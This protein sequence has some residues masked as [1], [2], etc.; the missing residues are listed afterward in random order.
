M[1]EK[2][3]KTA[4]LN[5]RISPTLKEATEKAAKE[6]SRS[7]TQTIEFL[8]KQYLKDKGYLNDDNQKK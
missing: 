6:D 4:T 1:T 2:R 3:K 8:L 5:L 7:V